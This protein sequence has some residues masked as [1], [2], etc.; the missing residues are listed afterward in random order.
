MH[1]E[2]QEELLPE[3]ETDGTEYEWEQNMSC[4]EDYGTVIR[5]RMKHAKAEDIWYR[6]ASIPNVVADPRP[7]D[8]YLAELE[9]RLEEDYPD[10]L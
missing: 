6:E 2:F 9:R 3:W 1:E 7:F 8:E 4:Q 5:L 10:G